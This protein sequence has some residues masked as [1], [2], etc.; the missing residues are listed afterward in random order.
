LN[1]HHPK[2]KIVLRCNTLL[3]LHEAAVQ[4]F[5]VVSLPCFLADPDPRLER[6]MQPPDELSAELWL[7]THPVLRR[8]A[9]V[10]AL[11]DFLAEALIKEKD[12]IEGCLTK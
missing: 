1:R 3:G 2:A 5:G 10:R 6:I 12:L 11:M 8:T 9:R 4:H 7:L